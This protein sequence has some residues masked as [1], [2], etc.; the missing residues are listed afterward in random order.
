MVRP[1]GRAAGGEA[2]RGSLDAGRI[3]D[4][5]RADEELRYCEANPHEAWIA[6]MFR[7]ARIDYGRIDYAVQAGVP[8]L[9]SWSEVAASV[10]RS[11]DKLLI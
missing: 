3:F 7:L 2:S 5:E 10:S 9:S 8:R 6:E 4:R 11:G 1:P